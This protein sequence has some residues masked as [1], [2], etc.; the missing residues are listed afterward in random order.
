[1]PR[2]CTLVRAVAFSNPY[3]R[4]NMLAHI[5]RAVRSQKLFKGAP[6]IIGVGETSRVRNM[7]QPRRAR[8]WSA[9]QFSK[10]HREHFSLCAMRISVESR[11][12]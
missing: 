1:M 9:V 2:G 6:V 4:A 12:P 11:P 5:L 10:L 8:E 7:P 3:L